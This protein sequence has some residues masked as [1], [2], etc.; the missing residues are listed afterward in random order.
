M[1]AQA[2]VKLLNC[3]SKAGLLDIDWKNPLLK[4]GSK[5]AAIMPS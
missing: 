1:F 3:S 2:S 4:E 5:Q